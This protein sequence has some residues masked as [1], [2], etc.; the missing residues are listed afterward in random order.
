MVD[1]LQVCLG[2]NCLRMSWFRVDCVAKLRDWGWGCEADGVEEL[3]LELGREDGRG[4]HEVIDGG[5]TKPDATAT[6]LREPGRCRDSD[7]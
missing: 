5:D 4:L 2:D 6:A 3:G 7:M 1:I